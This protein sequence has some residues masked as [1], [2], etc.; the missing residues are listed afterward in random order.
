[1]SNLLGLGVKAMLGGRTGI[2]MRCF[3][4][5]L[6]AADIT[7]ST[8]RYTYAFDFVA[9]IGLTTQFL[10]CFGKAT[11]HLATPILVVDCGRDAPAL[12][13]KAAS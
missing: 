5:S 4:S 9:L 7:R 12:W 2:F 11:F 13:S 1:M 6:A 3:A 8:I 10:L